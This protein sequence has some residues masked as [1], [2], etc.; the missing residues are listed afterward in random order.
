MHAG[1]YRICI[2]LITTYRFQCCPIE[3]LQN[4]HGQFDCAHEKILKSAQLH[5]QCYRACKQ[6]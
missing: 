3:F 6:R 2:D 1:F 4:H 5:A